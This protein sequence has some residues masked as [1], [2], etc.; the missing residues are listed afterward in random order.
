MVWGGFRIGLRRFSV[1][2]DDFRWFGLI[3]GGLGWVWDDFRWFGM[4]SDALGWVS[5]GF[6]MIVGSLG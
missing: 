4:G 6:R 5:G 2:C 3:L 1:A